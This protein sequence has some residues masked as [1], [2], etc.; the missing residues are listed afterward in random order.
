V[1]PPPHR[2]REGRE[3]II[4]VHGLVH[5]FGALLGRTGRAID[6]TARSRINGLVRERR[7]ERNGSRIRVAE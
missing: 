6:E 7:I 5:A 4:F 3:H 1:V 2:L